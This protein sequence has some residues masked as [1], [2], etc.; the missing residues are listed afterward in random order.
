MLSACCA[1]TL[2]AQR[3]DS[4]TVA[5]RVVAATA[6]AAKEYA[7]GVPGPGRRMVAPEEVEEAKGFLDAAI[8]DIPFLPTAARA[9][10][11]SGLHM[12]RA[13]LDRVAPA[14]SVAQRAATLV[15]RITTAAGGTLEA[16]PVHLPSRARGEAVYREQCIQCHGLAGRG[17]GPKAKH[18]TGPPA[19]DLGDRAD[20]DD[21]SP[22]DMYRKIAIGV[23]GTG[24]P[25]YA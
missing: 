5:R 25:E 22:E 19:A 11:D 2:A 24:M 12:L 23:S 15:Q 8:F 13:M 17:D 21:V 18:L 10:T 4:L 20:L 3:E 1:T 14:D 9:A 6:L 7:V 16:F